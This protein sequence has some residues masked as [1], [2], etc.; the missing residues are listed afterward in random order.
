MKRYEY[1][2][3]APGAYTVTRLRD[4]AGIGRVERLSI[5]GRKTALWTAL[6]HVGRKAHGFVTRDDAAFWLSRAH[7]KALAAEGSE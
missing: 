6:P 7:D 2:L 1:K 5:P 3:A 4:G